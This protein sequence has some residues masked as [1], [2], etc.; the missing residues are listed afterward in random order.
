MLLPCKMRPTTKPEMQCIIHCYA[1]RPAEACHP[2]AFLSSGH[3]LQHLRAQ[4][5]RLGMV[6]VI[7]AEERS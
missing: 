1:H 7:S 4:R 3:S 5:H 6:S 2:V